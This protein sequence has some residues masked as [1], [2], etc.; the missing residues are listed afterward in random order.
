MFRV[1]SRASIG[2]LAV[3]GVLILAL[4]REQ[5]G[6]QGFL[7]G[8]GLAVLPVPPLMAVFHWLDR[9][10]PGPWPQHLFVFAWGACAA[11]LIAIVANSF[12]TRWIAAATLD[13][14]DADQLG[15]I[16]IAPVVEECAK[17][18]ALL[19]VFLFRGRRFTGITDAIV[20]AGFTATGFAFTEN[21][22]YLGNAFGED[23][24][25]GTS[26]LDSV[27]AA[28]FFV[29]VV[30][31]PFA[32]PLFTVWTGL[33]F[34]WAAFAAGR[35]RRTG[36]PL[37]GLALAMATHALWNSSSEFGEYGFYVVYATV[38]VPVFGVLA[39]LGVR[40]RGRREPL[41]VPAMRDAAYAGSA[42]GPYA[43]AAVDPYAGAA[44]PH[45][46]GA[47]DPYPPGAVDPYPGVVRPSDPCPAAMPAGRPSLRRSAL[48]GADGRP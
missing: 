48:P 15:S 46:P 17:A 24:G 18:A 39:W 5:T 25:S 42:A 21:I 22:L 4:V 44:A 2:L 23:L 11:A 13:P 7:V 3:A 41:F 16:A 26:L 28:T 9:T 30:M 36:L 12:A 47:V 31:S 1:L 38:M 35:W 40:A 27:T 6:T 33:G 19:L 8:L 20:V 37:A 10:K 14:R 29:R 32:H 34:C 45:P 43:A